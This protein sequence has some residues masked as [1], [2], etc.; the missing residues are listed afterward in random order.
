[1]PSEYYVDMSIVQSELRALQDRD[2]PE[3]GESV[4]DVQSLLDLEER[5]AVDERISKAKAYT[6]RLDST[7][8]SSLTGHVFV[9]GKHFALDDVSSL[10]CE[11]NMLR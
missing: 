11:K 3:E 5:A 4:V 9:N 8:A 7:L 2:L 1:M 6:V 10:S